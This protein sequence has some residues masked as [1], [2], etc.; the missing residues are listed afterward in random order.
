MGTHSDIG[1]PSGGGSRK[2]ET[3]G[4]IDLGGAHDMAYWVKVL[5]T[6]PERLR[7][8]VDAVGTDAVKVSEYLRGDSGENPPGAPQIP[9]GG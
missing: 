6:T 5:D 1:P 8:A 7:E 9:D 2:L 4:V 3:R